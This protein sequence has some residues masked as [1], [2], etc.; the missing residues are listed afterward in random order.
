MDLSSNLVALRKMNYAM[1]DVLEAWDTL[2]TF[3]SYERTPKRVK[4]LRSTYEIQGDVDEWIENKESNIIEEYSKLRGIS[5]VEAVRELVERPTKPWPD[6]KRN[7]GPSFSEAMKA[8]PACIAGGLDR[9]ET[10][11][12]LVYQALHELDMYSEGQDGAITARQAAV[13]RKFIQKFRTT[14]G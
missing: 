7:P 11:S 12:D 9:P 5:F 6:A 2:K 13:V 3:T 1:T 10:V 14:E 8:F 4:W